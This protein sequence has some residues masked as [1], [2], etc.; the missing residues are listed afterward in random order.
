M[1]EANRPS[2]EVTIA[3]DVPDWDAIQ[4]RERATLRELG[5]QIGYGRCIQILEEEWARKLQSDPLWPQPKQVAEMAAGTICV[6]CHTDRRTG[7]V[8][9]VAH[10]KKPR[11]RKS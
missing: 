6:W 10:S 1:S 8:V 3:F 9:K 2:N 11:R 4:R 5:E 7:K